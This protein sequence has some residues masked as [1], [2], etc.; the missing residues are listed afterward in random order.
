VRGVVV[1]RDDRRF[2]VMM[3]EPWSDA[4]WHCLTASGARSLAAGRQSLVT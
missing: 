2:G 3:L 1:Y 4:E